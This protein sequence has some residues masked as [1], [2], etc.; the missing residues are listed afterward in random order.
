MSTRSMIELY[1]EHDWEPQL[2]ARLYCHC[3]GYPEA[4]APRLYGYLR[5]AA[6]HPLVEHGHW[7]SHEIAAVLVKLAL[8]DDGK[9]PFLPYVAR[10]GDAAYTW[11][12]YIDPDQPSDFHFECEDRNGSL[13]DLEAFGHRAVYECELV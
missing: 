1:D 7:Q 5:E 2:R 9:S 13:V 10:A 3:D 6:Q 4:M 8:E 12:V 11:K